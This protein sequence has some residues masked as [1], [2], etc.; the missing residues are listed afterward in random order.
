MAAHTVSATEVSYTRQSA[1][2]G[3][4]SYKAVDHTRQ[5][6]I[7]GSRPYKAVGHTRQSA[8]QGSRPYKAVSHTRWPLGL[9]DQSGIHAQ[10]ENENPTKH[11]VLGG[12]KPGC[13]Q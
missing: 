1:I 2:Q 12:F 11:Y 10:C 5:S 7:Q 9:I 3:S 13:L 6:V 8:I 4:R